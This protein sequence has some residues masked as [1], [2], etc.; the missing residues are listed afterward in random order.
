MSFHVI[1]RAE[2]GWTIAVLFLNEGG[3]EESPGSKGQGAR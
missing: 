1:I 2:V 3:K